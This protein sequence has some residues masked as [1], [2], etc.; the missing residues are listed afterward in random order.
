MAEDAQ[1]DLQIRVVDPGREEDWSAV[2]EGLSRRDGRPWTR[3]ACMRALDGLAP[4]RCFALVAM[5]G[6]SAVGLS[7]A[8]LRTLQIDGEYG[9]VAY[10]ANLFVDPSMRKT[11]LYPR[12]V[13]ATTQEARKRGLAGT[14]ASVRLPDLSKAHQRLGFVKTAEKVVLAKPIRPLRTAAR[15]LGLPEP[16]IAMAGVLDPI[17]SRIL[18][19]RPKGSCQSIRC[20]VPADLPEPVAALLMSPIETDGLRRDLA[21][22]Q[23]RLRRW[24]GPHPYSALWLEEGGVPVA[25]AL[26]AKAERNDGY[27]LGVI[28]DLVSPTQSAAAA[29]LTHLER[30][31]LA[32]GE[33]MVLWMPT[34]PGHAALAAQRGYRTTPERYEL[35]AHPATLGERLKT[36]LMPGWPLTF[37]DHDAF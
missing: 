34:T 27:R 35:L 17:P 37:L 19:P 3:E 8:F 15:Y 25:A 24:K 12:L 7:T 33:D 31:C 23:G 29:L 28:L 36:G 10:W 5:T 2:A 22:I 21:W 26:L 16:L 32:R 13:L 9:Q 11:L 1:A 20:S 18:C 6:Q 30:T 4:D 14:I